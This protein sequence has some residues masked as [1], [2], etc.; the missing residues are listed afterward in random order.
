MTGLEIESE[1][2]SD[3]ERNGVAGREEESQEANG[4]SEAGRR[5]DEQSHRLTTC[6]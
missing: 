3:E 4:L 5:I 1:K 2:E 6:R